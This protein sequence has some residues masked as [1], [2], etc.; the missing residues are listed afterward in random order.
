MLPRLRRRRLLR[1]SRMPLLLP[2]RLLRLKRILLTLPKLTKNP[3]RKSLRELPR[4]RSRRKS[5]KLRLSNRHQSQLILNSHGA[6]HPRSGPLTCQPTT[7]RDM[8]SRTKKMSKSNNSPKLKMRMKRRMSPN[9][10]AS[11]R[12]KTL[13][14]SKTS[15]LVDKSLVQNKFEIFKFT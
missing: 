12:T 11:L 3:L 2:R 7:S 14:M 15:E 8:P 6:L 10:R 5:R 9:L 4:S 13:A 1:L